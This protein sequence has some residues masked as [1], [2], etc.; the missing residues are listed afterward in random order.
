MGGPFPRR[1][2]PA[3]RAAARRALRVTIAAGT[4]FYV[5]LYGFDLAVGATYALFGAIAMAGLS[6]LPGSGRQRA[7]LLVSVVPVCW[8]LITLGTY[9]SVRTWS[10]VLGMLVVGF[11]LAFMAVGGP[12]FAGAAT[13][14]QL[15]YILPSFPPYDPGSLGERLAGATFGL[16]L[17]IVAEI[18]LLPEPPA[19]PYRER[20]ARAADGAARCAAR[21]RT[22]P[23]TLPE[24]AQRTARALSTGL[25]SSQVP[26]A[27]RPAGAGVRQRALAHTGLATRTL[28]GRLTVLPPPPQGAVPPADDDG[29]GAAE[30]A[31]AGATQRPDPLRAVMEVARE[32][33]DRLRG[34]VPDGRAHTALQQE[35]QA[36]AAAEDG[37]PAAL[38][39]NAA[40]LEVAD[41][42]LAMSTAADIAVRGRAADVP[43]PGRFWYARQRAPRLWWRRLSG[44]AAGRSVFF[45]NAVRISLALAAARLIA[46][47]DTLPHG[48]W[49]LLATLTLTRTTVRETRKTERKALTGTL[50]G[51]LVAATLLAVV[52][53][54]IEVYA[55]ALPPLML[56]TFTLGPVKGVGWAQALFTVVVALVFAQLA[57]ATWQLAEFRLLDVL[58]GSAIGAV[59][60]LLAWPRGAHDEL[61]RSVAVLLR[62]A[63]EIVVATT[64]QIAAGGR[65]VPVV[66]APGHRSLQHALVMAESA[67]AQ[68]QSE[69]QGLGPPQVRRDWQAALIAAHHTL[70]GADRLLVPAE[71]VVIPPLGREASESVIRTGDRVA[72]GMLL[73][74]ARMDPTGDTA[75]TP[76]PL[77]APTA[78]ATMA[79]DPPGAARAYYATMSWLASLATDLERLA[80]ENATETDTDT[81]TE[82]D[83]KQGQG[84]RQRATTVAASRAHPASAPDDP[85]STHEQ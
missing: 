83:S 29:A 82:S 47:I 25:R 48:F 14:L 43:A 37:S 12:R 68:Y 56:V 3:Y 2:P 49:V 11:A 79:A 6:H 46:G 16:A 75:E 33:A 36:L 52:G 19:L 31:Q 55:V 21:L 78:S 42:A 81:D 60:G 66:T 9:L 38:R 50:V 65:R 53:T 26:E 22:A 71:P 80:A 45:Q 63:A 28:L 5:L 72:A 41:A 76:A 1:L 64:A 67:Y 70:W 13:G 73:T 84:Q 34:R 4:G 32:T 18:T 58:T 24:A 85:R 54:D 27:E 51:A 15:M 20:A 23:Y 8:V 77:R 44:H 39:R 40:L 57:P 7:T 10:A 17:L 59:F 61:R 69:P 30:G 74:S 62:I 35:R